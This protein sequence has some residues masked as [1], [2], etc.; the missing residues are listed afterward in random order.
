MKKR[1]SLNRVRLSDE[2]K[3]KLA[4]EIRAFYLDQQGEEVGIIQQMQLLELIEE[5]IGPMIYNKALNDARRWFAQIMDNVDSDY[6]T[7][8]K[9]E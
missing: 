3:E 5:K 7:L 6:Y 1:E 4:G 8:Y 2:E 9:G